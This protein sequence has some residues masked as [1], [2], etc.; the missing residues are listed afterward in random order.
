[1]ASR[2]S[3]SRTS[4]RILV[5]ADDE[6]VRGLLNRALVEDGYEAVGVDDRRE[7]VAGMAP[8]CS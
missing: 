8:E 5:V 2:R 3:T 6:V 7:T 1:V 4:Y